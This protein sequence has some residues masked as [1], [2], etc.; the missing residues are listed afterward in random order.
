ME[1]SLQDATSLLLACADGNLSAVKHMIED[2]GWGVDVNATAT[3]YPTV[4]NSTYYSSLLPRR[5]EGA[6]PL[7]VAAVHGHIDI[8][9]FLCMKGADLSAKTSSSSST[10]NNLTP[11]YGA[12]MTFDEV[13]SDDWPFNYPVKSPLREKKIEVVRH[14]L[15][16][17][18]DPSAHSIDDSLYGR[19]TTECVYD[20]PT[21]MMNLSYSDVTAASELIS[22]GLSLEMRK[23][24]YDFTVLHHWVSNPHWIRKTAD[25]S[26]LD[27]VKLL[28]RMG[29]DLTDRDEHDFS[30]IMLAAHG[31]LAQSSRESFDIFNYLLERMEIHLEEKIDA[32]ELIGAVILS[33]PENAHLFHHAFNFWRRAQYLRGM[34]IEG[35]GPFP[36]IVMNRRIGFTVEWSSHEELEDIIKKPSDYPIQAFLVKLRIYSKIRGLGWKMFEFLNRKFLTSFCNHLSALKEQLNLTTLLEMLC[37]ILEMILSF[38]PYS[39]IELF[40]WNTIDMVVKEIV[41]I[42]TYFPMLTTEVIRIPL[43]LMLTAEQIIFDSDLHSHKQLHVD[44]NFISDGERDGMLKFLQLVTTKVSQEEEIKRLLMRLF[45]LK[46]TTYNG[47]F[48][49]NMVCGDHYSNLATVRF[50]LQCGVDP[51]AGDANGNGPL[52]HLLR[53]GDQSDLHKRNDYAILRLFLDFG[54]RL[55]RR[56]NAGKTPVDLWTEFQLNNW[57]Q[58]PEE[59]I[60]DRLPDWCYLHLPRLKVLSSRAVRSNDIP[61][62]EKTLPATLCKFVENQE[63]L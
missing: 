27:V 43:Q 45:R 38:Q 30:P 36:K 20:Y 2:P 16:K 18:A 23:P 13:G 10:Y 50:F 40:F 5:I 35:S 61:F 28:V 1:D 55:D 12:L 24:Y 8:V 56:N 21:W 31:F 59:F 47:K 39:Y 6:T 15:S 3:Y 17:G 37:A 19:M 14:L 9:K 51:N 32:C 7:F 22:G 49:L 26:P 62:S 52:H 4:Y 41:E 48:L 63:M 34:V 11:L 44:R 29:V 25:E 54:G 33:N 42:L 57:N 58:H 60:L 46:R 53:H